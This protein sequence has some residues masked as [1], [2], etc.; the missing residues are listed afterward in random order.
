MDHF[1]TKPPSIKQNKPITYNS[2]ILLMGSCFVENIGKKLNYYKF[3]NSVNP[4][5][6]IF[7]P[8]AIETLITR[9]LEKRAYTEKDIFF[10]NEQWHS[11]EIH[12]RLSSTNKK[13][14]LDSLNT[15]LEQSHKQLSEASQVILTY[16]TAWGYKPIQNKKIAANCHKVPQKKFQKKLSTVDA[17]EKNIE[18]TFN[19]ILKINPLTQIITTISPVRHIK[20]GLL[21]NNRSKA[22]L[23]AALHTVMEKT[24]NV[25]Y[26]PAYE[27]VMDCLREYRFYEADLIHPNKIAIDFIWDHFKKSW[28]HGADTENTLKIINEIQKGLAH[29]PFNTNGEAHQKFLSSIALKKEHIQK[30]YS[31]IIF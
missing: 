31:F 5:G 6:I 15:I 27:L 16:G 12:S 21:E 8:E 26:Y 18:N 4:F 17:L 24:T 10:H 1:F 25:F 28:I 19:A 11:F 29:K 13:Q 3:Q 30:K 9:V 7:H 14:F 20:D 2:K 23:I 22:N